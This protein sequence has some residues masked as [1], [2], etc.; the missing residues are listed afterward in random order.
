MPLFTWKP[1]AGKQSYFV[2]VAK[3]ASF[4]NIVDYAFTH[5]RPTRLVD[6]RRRR[7]IRTK[8]R[9]ITGWSCR[10]P[11]ADGGGAPATRERL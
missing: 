1:L 3:D 7:L 10:R 4:W 9:S 6:E 11:D 5:F 8:R 2:L